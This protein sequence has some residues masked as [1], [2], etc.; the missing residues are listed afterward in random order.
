MSYHAVGIKELPE[1]MRPREKLAKFGEGRLDDH[2]L[3]AII[4]GMGTTKINALDLARQIMIKYRTLRRLKEASLEELMSERG[5][6]MAKAVSI[7]AAIEL[8]RR[9]AL[10]QE[11]KP[12]ITSP[13]D[14]KTLVMEDMRYLDREH[15][16]VIYL[17]RKGGIIV[18]EDISVGGLH[19]S[20]AHPREVFKNAVKRSAASI[21][22]VHNH[23]SGDPHPSNEDMETTRRLVE[24]GQIVGI[25]VLDHV[26][27]GDNK[28]CSMKSRGLI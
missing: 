15:F 10:S 7:K 27:I 2:E 16:K 13:E 17:D 23:P 3:I 20:M 8:G 9:L 24:A 4:L 21:I 26:I 19:S 6:G 1:D 22:L 25:E 14:V 5:I 28:Y 12:V 18:T 11:S